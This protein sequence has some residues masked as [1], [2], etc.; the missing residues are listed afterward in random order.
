MKRMLFTGALLLLTVLGLRAQSYV[1][2]TEGEIPQEA[3][4]V[5][6]QRFTQML[7]AGGL[8]VSE[9]GTPLTVGFEVKDRMETPGSMS[10]VALQLEIKAA[11]GEVEEVFPVKGVGENEADAWLRAVKQL[12]PRSKA[13]RSFVEKLK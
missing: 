2:R 1:I 9:A 5:L 3:E 6:V 8:T 7:E 4:K 11:A 12:L 10:Q 13:A